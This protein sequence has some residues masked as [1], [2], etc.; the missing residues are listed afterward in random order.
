MSL[1]AFE[2]GDRPHTVVWDAAN[3]PPSARARRTPKRLPARARERL[4]APLGLAARLLPI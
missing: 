4:A 2:I 3:V 1:F